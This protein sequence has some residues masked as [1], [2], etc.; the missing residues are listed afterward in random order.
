MAY[1][2]AG[3][4]AVIEGWQFLGQGE[5][6]LARQQF[7]LAAALGMAD[8]WIQLAMMAWKDGDKETASTYLR[9]AEVMAEA[10]DVEANI[11]CWRVH[12]IGLI[13]SPEEHKR[14]ELHFLRRAAE[15]GD[16]QAQLRMAF[17]ALRGRNGT[18]KDEAQYDLWI[19]RALAQ[20]DSEGSVLCDHI[21][22]LLELKRPVPAPL[23]ERLRPAAEISPAAALLLSQ[24]AP[25]FEISSTDVFDLAVLRDIGWRFW[26]PIGL[27]GE[28]ADWRNEPGFADE[29]DDYL[30]EIA[31]RLQRGDS[32][33]DVVDYL[34][35]IESEFIG[36]GFQPDAYLRATDVAQRVKAYIEAKRPSFQ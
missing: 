27:L 25:D 31:E 23:I 16:R 26:D 33:K 3:F 35:A 8:G 15:L 5:K 24:V 30:L 12:E 36:L 14:K 4:A 2:E 32:E 13:T 22:I 21:Q 29:Y 19:G 17:D 11:A 1:S 18:L 10:D 6:T 28:D 20:D 9:K 7:N 34:V